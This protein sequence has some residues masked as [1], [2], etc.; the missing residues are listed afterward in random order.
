VQRQAVLVHGR[1]VV[2][3]TA[4]DDGPVVVLV[5]GITQDSTTWDE[6]G[7]RLGA[8]A[9]VIAVDLP[10]HGGSDNPAGDHSIGAY[11]STV[12]DLLVLLDV[13]SATVVG[14]SL[15][16]GVALQF[17][18]QF[19]EMLDRLVLLDAGGLGREVSP[20]LRA[21][22]LPGAET[23]LSLLSSR[24]ALAL[25]GLATRAAVALGHRHTD[26][27]GVRQGL[28]GL[29]DRDNRRAFVHTVRATMGLRGQRVSAQ[30]KLYLAELVPTLLL[31]G[32]DDRIIPVSH[33]HAAH[34]LIPQNE[35]RIIPDAGHFPH[36]DQPDAVLRH[37]QEFLR[38][39]D[40]AAVPREAWGQ[41][42]REANPLDR[43][44]G[45]GGSS[46]GRSGMVGP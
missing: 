16:G 46:A 41:V 38:R 9:R 39:T 33:A 19:P 1:R 31:W 36:V 6:L 43:P 25:T 21:A 3:R 28:A 44:G 40:A 23:V 17:A 2:Y 13:D 35:L 37:I 4:G 10:G 29:A 27:S 30:D 24:P 22:A 11:A 20:L 15:G 18:Y 34:E 32:Q 12:R 8:T 14:H 45:P 26:L 5:H 7:D 42:L